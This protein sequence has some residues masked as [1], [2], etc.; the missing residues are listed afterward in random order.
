MGT[1]REIQIFA[2]VLKTPDNKTILIPNGSLA[3]GSM[4][5]FSVEEKR[6]VDWTFGIGYGDDIDKAYEVIK[7]LLSEDERILDDP[8]P[9]LALKELGDSSVD[10][11]V[12][13]WVKA[14]D[15]WP[16]HFRMNEEVYKTFE[17][18]GLSIPF[19]QRDVHIHNQN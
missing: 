1:V 12:R 5:N 4:T 3:N 13:V 14:G 11:T 7:R 8:Q 18:E 17:K 16:V 19:P 9:F 10:I 2:T 6:R 15:F